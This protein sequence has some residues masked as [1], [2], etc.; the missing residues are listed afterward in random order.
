MGSH[1]YSKLIFHKGAKANKWK[2][3]IFF[4]ANS[5]RTVG[6]PYG[7]KLTQTLN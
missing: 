1:K 5:A 2:M 6:Y 4:S 3:I 7:K